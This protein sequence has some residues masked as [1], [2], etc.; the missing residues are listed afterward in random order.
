MQNNFYE[1]LSDLMVVDPL[2]FRLNIYTR[3]Q[4]LFIQIVISEYARCY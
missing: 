1:T 2:L 4:Q 3:N